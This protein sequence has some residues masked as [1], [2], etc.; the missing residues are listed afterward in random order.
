MEEEKK[1]KEEV[2]L[3]KRGRKKKGEKRVFVLNMDQSKFVVDLAGDKNSLQLVFKFLAKANK[4]D[5]GG[6]VTFKDLA[7]LG[8]SK[9]TDKDI[10]Q[11]KEQSL[12]EMEKVERALI[13]YN[14]K[15]G[16]KLSLGEFLV[17]KLALN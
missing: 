9:I 1:K 16:T 4:K 5:L 15:N 3:V 8:L 7:V 12:T 10:E 2:I 14:S 11:L 13:K 17:K 6:E